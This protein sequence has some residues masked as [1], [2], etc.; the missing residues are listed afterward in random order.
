MCIYDLV[1]L[2]KCGC[3]VYVGLCVSGHMYECLT[4]CLYP[5]L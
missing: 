3:G 1:Y 4:V 5:G 2:H